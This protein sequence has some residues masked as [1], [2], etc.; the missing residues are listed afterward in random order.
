VSQ[1]ELKKIK[2]VIEHWPLGG[3]VYLK[4]DPEQ[5]KRMI[6]GFTVFEKD[7]LYSLKVGEN[8]SEHYDYEL[9]FEPNVII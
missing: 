3:F 6:V 8:D 7:L 2:S 1:K 5:L 9:D 4:H